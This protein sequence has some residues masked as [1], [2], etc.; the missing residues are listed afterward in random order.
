MVDYTKTPSNAPS[1]LDKSEQMVTFRAWWRADEEHSSTWRWDAR[2][3]FKFIAGHQ[4]DDNDKAILKD[5]KRTPVTF[6][7]S[8]PFIK[9]IC[10]T[11]INQRHEIRYIPRGLEDAQVNELLTAA[12]KW[13]ADGEDAE[14]E[15][16]SAF[17]HATICGMGW[18]ECRMDYETDPQGKYVEET[19]DP[20][21]IVWDCRARKKN[22]K[23][24]R[25]Q[26]HVRKMPRADAR[27]FVENVLGVEWDDSMDAILDA[28]WAHGYD[29][30]PGKTREQKIRR[31]G[32]STYSGDYED[33]VTIVRLQW[34]EKECYY[35]VVDPASQQMIDMSKEDFAILQERMKALGGAVK[36]ARLTRRVYKQVWL[37]QEILGEIEPAPLGDRFSF[38]CVTCEEDH[39]DGTWFGFGRIL[40]DPQKWANKWLS[41]TLHILNSTAKGGVMAELD[42]FKDQRQAEESWAK[43]DRIT[44]VSKGALSGTHGKKIEAKPAITFP[45]G[46]FDLTKF[47]ISVMP[48]VTGINLELLGQRDVTQPGV[49]EAQRKMAA[50]TMLATLFDSLRRY[51]K[52]IG[53]IRLFVIQNFISDG[54]LIRLT[55]QPKAVPLLKDKTAGEYDVV[56][57]DAPTSPNEKE[58]NW[59]LIAPLLPVF[60]DELAARP[61]ALL[62]V[63][64]YSPLPSE[65]VNTLAQVIAAPPSPA[66]Q[67]AQQLSEN[68]VVAAIEK[69]AS[70]AEL[71]RS[72]AGATQA[73]ELYDLAMAH[74]L[75]SKDPDGD[76][77]KRTPIEA[78]MDT[79][80][81]A[82]DI[83]TKKA[84]KDKAQADTVASLAK[85]HATLHPPARPQASQ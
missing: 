69:D 27:D 34:W 35:K 77:D 84:Q 39:V 52:N 11:E 8:L 71:N 62:A 4:W 14:D 57:D 38:E 17:K 75:L 82:A 49:L 13:M 65:L 45:Q 78:I 56:V 29:V 36:A 68:R 47:A 28:T 37:G 76:G 60:R 72:K 81:K 61:E 79:L 55:N 44:W 7:M 1:T 50:M 20:L 58:K 6:N 67:R 5:Q 22:L 19:I 32:T 23:D 15:E 40:R 64:R 33:E 48:D 70:T 30:E 10:G 54:R 63:L 66:Q 25:R 51:R 26:W 21:E 24:R 12:S 59:A 31:T 9:A 41:Q 73:T 53:R 16:S 46:Y 74:N 2:Q 18:T 80:N 85:A 43:Q 3:D 83:D 42:A